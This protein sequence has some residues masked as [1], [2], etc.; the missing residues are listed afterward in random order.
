MP[1]IR[2]PMSI[3]SSEIMLWKRA[4]HKYVDIHVYLQIYE[5]LFPK[6]QSTNW[7][8][9]AHLSYLCATALIVFWT[10]ALQIIF[11]TPNPLLANNTRKYY[12]I[13]SGTHCV[14]E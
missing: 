4:L 13:E 14:W 5:E 12:G 3:Q 8:L 10:R 9:E 1:E 7:A 11:S 6:T 2:F